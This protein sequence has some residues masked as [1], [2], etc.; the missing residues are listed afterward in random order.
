MCPSLVTQ[1]SVDL[2][3]LEEGSTCVTSQQSDL[4][5]PTVLQYAFFELFHSTLDI[6]T[7]CSIEPGGKRGRA[8]TDRSPCEGHDNKPADAPHCSR[9]ISR[10]DS[11][12]QGN[13]NVMHSVSISDILRQELCRPGL[14][15]PYSDE[16]V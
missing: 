9:L 12:V 2:P 7:S 16:D 3:S 10:V 13:R 6:D 8:A 15:R 14:W 11:M 4:H 5:G 1:T